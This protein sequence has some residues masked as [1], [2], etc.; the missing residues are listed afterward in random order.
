M[1]EQVFLLQWRANMLQSQNSLGQGWCRRTATSYKRN[2]HF[3]A[4]AAEAA[5]QMTSIL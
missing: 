5:T 4:G 3:S 1:K 2:R